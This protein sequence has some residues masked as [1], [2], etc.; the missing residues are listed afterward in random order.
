MSTTYKLS[1][2]VEMFVKRYNCV[3][4]VAASGAVGSFV[5]DEILS[6]TKETTA[7][8]YTIELGDINGE[9]TLVSVKNVDCVLSGATLDDV[10]PHVLTDALS[11]TGKLVLQLHTAGTEADVTAANKIHLTITANVTGV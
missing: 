1:N 10:T 9:A 7:G 3:I 4:T 2:D 8:Q 11:S 5:G 6:V